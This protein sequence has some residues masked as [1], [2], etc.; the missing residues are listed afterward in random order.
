MGSWAPWDYIIAYVGITGFALLFMYWTHK[1]AMESLKKAYEDRIV[2]Q[3]LMIM[4][5]QNLIAISEDQT[6]RERDRKD[7]S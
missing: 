1:R 6:R 7:E 4:M 5:L 2:E 3:K